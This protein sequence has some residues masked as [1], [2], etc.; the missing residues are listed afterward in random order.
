MKKAEKEKRLE[1]QRLLLE[2]LASGEKQL[3]RAEGSPRHYRFSP[4]NPAE[5]RASF[6]NGGRRNG[7][8]SLMADAGGTDTALYPDG[9]Q[10][11]AL[12][13]LLG[14]WSRKKKSLYFCM[15]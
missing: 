2:Y 5:K 8:M 3:P 10:A 13:A 14:N 9:E 12:S 15:A 6:G 4:Q 11:A 1:G 7:E